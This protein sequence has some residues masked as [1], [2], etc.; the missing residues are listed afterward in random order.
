ME[1]RTNSVIALNPLLRSLSNT[2]NQWKS[3]PSHQERIGRALPPS[4]RHLP[5]GMLHACSSS[6]ARDLCDRLQK[7]RRLQLDHTA[8]QRTTSRV[9]CCQVDTNRHRSGVRVQSLG[10]GSVNIPT[11]RGLGQ[12]I[13]RRV[14]RCGTLGSSKLEGSGCSRRWDDTT[15]L[16]N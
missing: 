1:T 6:N 3:R 8:A 7:E 9:T 13:S 11:R 4:R 14:W 15:R 16:I 12:I 2:R 5:R 10:S